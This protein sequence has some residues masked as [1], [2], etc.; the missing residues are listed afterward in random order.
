[1]H[2]GGE[3]VSEVMSRTPED[4]MAEGDLGD[5]LGRKPGGLYE[6]RRR[7]RSGGA[8]GEAPERLP[9]P[10]LLKRASDNG[11]VAFSWTSCSALYTVFRQELEAERPRASWRL[12]SAESLSD[13]S[14]EELRQ[15]VQE[16]TE[17]VELLRCELE[18]TQRHLEG[19]HEALKILQSRA[20]FDKAT[21]HTK[22]LLQK[23][24][25]RN[26]ALEKE[27]NALQWEI[28]FNQVQFKNFEQ[29]WKEKYDRVC[30][31]NKALSNTV[32]DRAR[33][34]QELRSE[35][36]SL[37]QQCLELLAMLSVPEQKAFQGSL[38]PRNNL[39]RD[40][41]ALELAVLG[42]CHCSASVRDTC[43]CPCARTA[44]AS[45]KQVL[46]LKQELEVQRRRKEEAYVMADAFRIAFE[47]QLKRK[48]EHVL[49]LAE[50][51][52]YLR[53]DTPQAR[54]EEAVKGGSGSMAQ[55]LRGMLQNTG[56]KISDDPAETLHNLVDL[57]NDKEEALAHQRKV[58][59]MLARNAEELERRL[60]QVKGQDCATRGQ[61]TR[62]EGQGGGG[63]RTPPSKTPDA[64]GD[65]GEDTGAHAQCL[66]TGE[67]PVECAATATACGGES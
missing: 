45:R 64:Q 57:L 23:S 62:Q 60:L 47:Q 39:G 5:G 49:R 16:V 13:L 33:E 32:S 22:T 48:S 61:E 67:P 56:V 25:E 37:S 9:S 41:T 51:E 54:K 12:S 15:R 46:Q 38:P 18:A 14:N 2:A 17:E 31:E 24:E 28:T 20:V 43:P 44:A 63:S 8:R 10:G 40:G 21:S 4:D 7:T 53:K 11:S 66:E 1:M 52:G 26:K 6:R 58:S 65:P 34:M 29:S 42:A 55:R 59:Y 36:S 27:V 50:T 30:S 19:K 35:N 3:Q